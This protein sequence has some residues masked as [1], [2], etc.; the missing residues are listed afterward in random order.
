MEYDYSDGILC[1]GADV[2]YRIDVAVLP[3]VDCRRKMINHI[4]ALLT[5]AYIQCAALAQIF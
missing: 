5:P 2:N 1:Y 3:H 4:L